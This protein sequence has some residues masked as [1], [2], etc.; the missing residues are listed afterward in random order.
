MNKSVSNPKA[1]LNNPERRKTPLRDAVHVALV[2]Y[3]KNLDGDHPCDLYQMVL[4]EIEPPTLQAVMNYTCGNQSKAA[5][6]LG[7]NRSTL[8][9]KLGQYGLDK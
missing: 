5:E 2:T 3:F 7:M 1:H 4:S 8:R 6:I 9:K